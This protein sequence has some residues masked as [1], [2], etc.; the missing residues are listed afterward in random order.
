[1]IFT[2]KNQVDFFHSPVVNCFYRTIAANEK[3]VVIVAHDGKGHNTIKVY[4]TEL[5]FLAAKKILLKKTDYSFNIS[6]EQTNQ[7][8][9]STSW[10]FI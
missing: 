2:T 4:D 8:S 6:R 3:Y 10:N 7:V 5:N 9:T 1:M